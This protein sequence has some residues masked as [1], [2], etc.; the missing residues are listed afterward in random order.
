MEK[1]PK[2]PQKF[3]CINCDYISCSIKDYKKHILTDKHQ[4]RTNLNDLEQKIPK[5]PKEFICSA[6]KKCYKARNS[7]WYHEQKCLKKN[8]NNSE[9]IMSND[10]SDKE[11]IMLLSKENSE[12]KNMMMKVIV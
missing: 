8:F 12:L 10:P 11:L 9:S 7:L 1:I 2:N 5:N 3:E 4:N 6:C